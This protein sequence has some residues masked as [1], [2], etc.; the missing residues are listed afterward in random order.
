MFGNELYSI[1]RYPQE[2]TNKDMVMA[3]K[4]KSKFE[5]EMSLEFVIYFVLIRL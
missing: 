5:K 4:T 1:I 3:I 2:I